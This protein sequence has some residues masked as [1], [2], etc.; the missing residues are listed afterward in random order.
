MAISINCKKSFQQKKTFAYNICR[1]FW[2]HK[3]QNQIHLQQQ[4]TIAE[5]KKIEFDWGQCTIS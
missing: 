3:F 1:G 2:G 4:P 5:I